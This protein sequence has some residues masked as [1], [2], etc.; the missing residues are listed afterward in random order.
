MEVTDID[1]LGKKIKE[2]R[3][4]L[5]L[6]QEILAEQIEISLKSI[7]R[8][9]SDKSRPDTYALVKLA[10]YFDVS[11]DYLL[12]L[13]AIKED[14][15]EKSNKV[16][17]NGKYNELYSWYLRCKNNI[18]VDQSAVYYWIHFGDDGMIGGQT[19]WVGWADED[20]KIE[21]RRLRPVIPVKAIEGCTKVF[22]RPLLINEEK[23]VVVFRLFGGHAIVKQEICERFLPEFLED[24][25]GTTPE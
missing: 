15:K 4:A 18:E 10:T 24:F 7:Q 19:E 21:I 14:L 23:D 1:T 6:S 12:G 20:Y 22:G 17:Q 9:E 13:L 3:N 2:L 5:G 11:T 16:L 8:Y 25:I